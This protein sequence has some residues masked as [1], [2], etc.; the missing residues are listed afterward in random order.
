MK[1]ILGQHKSSL[2]RRRKMWHR[3][4]NDPQPG[5]QPP[6]AELGPLGEGRAL[7]VTRG[8][9]TALAPAVR[10]YKIKEESKANTKGRSERKPKTVG[11]LETR[12][13][14]GSEVL[15]CQSLAT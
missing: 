5:K 8:D 6:R 3:R 14:Q 9:V 15:P 1:I 2:K 10:K 13:W 4:R 11:D 7:A 12:L